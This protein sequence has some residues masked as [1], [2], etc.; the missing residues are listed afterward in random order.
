MLSNNL[1][2]GKGFLEGSVEVVCISILGMVGDKDTIVLVLGN[3]TG[4]DNLSLHRPVFS[5][6][7][8]GDNGGRGSSLVVEPDAGRGV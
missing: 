1:R 2:M 6:V 4:G 5:A 3:L 7:V 8:G